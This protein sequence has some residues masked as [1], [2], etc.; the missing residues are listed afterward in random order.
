MDL[1]RL[2]LSRQPLEK[3]LQLPNLGDRFWRIRTNVLL[4]EDPIL[5]DPTSYFMMKGE[6]TS[7][8]P[9]KVDIG[10]LLDRAIFLRNGLSYAYYASTLRAYGNQS[11]LSLE[12]A[13]ES[14]VPEIQTASLAIGW[15]DGRKYDYSQIPWTKQLERAVLHYGPKSVAMEHLD[16]PRDIP[17]LERKEYVDAD[18]VRGLVSSFTRGEETITTNHELTILYRSIM[19][20][21]KAKGKRVIKEGDDEDF[22]SEG[23]LY[24]LLV[25]NP[26]EI[27]V[28]YNIKAYA[29][30]FARAPLLKKWKYATLPP[31]WIEAFFI[32]IDESSVTRKLRDRIEAI[33][34][35]ADLFNSLEEEIRTVYLLILGYKISIPQN[36][37]LSDDF[38]MAI[39]AKVGY[40]LQDLPESYQ[41]ASVN[42]R[43]QEDDICYDPVGWYEFVMKRVRDPYVYTTQKLTR[44]LR[45]YKE[46]AYKL[47][48]AN[49]SML[50]LVSSKQST[51][52][53]E[54]SNYQEILSSLVG[55]N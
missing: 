24:F 14:G 51:E 28:I 5:L 48:L 37:D 43:V 20:A 4:H 1:L 52:V 17:I 32:A 9:E 38:Y 40:P 34:A 44:A 33:H 18:N 49:K 19:D 39:L 47:G 6:L 35:D 27:T 29:A 25:A 46:R 15:F 42:V 55:E 3:L 36:P 30:A 12:A 50:P 10:F 23:H 26:K 22:I 2:V 16:L 21:R 53:R 31:V 7:R 13:L 45:F 11:P 54:I 8:S 41:R